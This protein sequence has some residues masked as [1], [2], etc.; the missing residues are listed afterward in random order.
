MLVVP[1][2]IRN[3]NVPNTAEVA[4][5]VTTIIKGLSDLAIFRILESY[6]LPNRSPSV[7]SNLTDKPNHGICHFISCHVFPAAL[8]IPF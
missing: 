3:R 5:F 7:Y 6:S 8:S 2:Q 4:I 1:A